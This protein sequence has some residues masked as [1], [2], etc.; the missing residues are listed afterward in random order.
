VLLVAC[1]ESA[2]AAPRGI[3]ESSVRES[4]D[5]TAG[6]QSALDANVRRCLPIAFSLPRF[7]AGNVHSSRGMLVEAVYFATGAQLGQITMTGTITVAREGATY[8][9]TP[10]DRLVV[11]IRGEVHEFVVKEVKGNNQAESAAGWLASPHVLHYTHK[12]GER[13]DAEIRVKFDGKRFDASA[14]GFVKVG[15]A[16]YDAIL[17][18]VGA[19]E[20]TRDLDGF[21]V[22]THYDLTGTISGEGCEIAVNEHHVLKSA[23]AY[24]L[25]LLTTQRGSA[26]RIDARL[27]NVL[28]CGGST[29]E[30]SNVD[31]RSET[32]DKGREQRSGI[33]AV[34]GSILRDRAPFATCALQSGAVHATVGAEVLRLDEIA[35]N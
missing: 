16:R 25:R 34:T 7:I 19:T 22:A 28:K 30:L 10:A 11:K 26:S 2:V 9:P 27:A 8:A 3:A 21:D 33:T 31:V 12:L 4:V 6:Q 14:K 18:A 20:G 13:A 15:A 24:S 23:G 17:T 5:E 1:D 29:Y 35:T 32:V